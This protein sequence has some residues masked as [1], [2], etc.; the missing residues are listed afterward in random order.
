MSPSIRLFLIGAVL[1]IHLPLAWSQMNIKVG[2]ITGRTEAQSYN[3]IV[4]HF[5]RNIE[6]VYV[7]DD[8][9]DPLR[10]MHGLE[11]GVRYKIRNVGFEL[12]WSGLQKRSDVFASQNNVNRLQSRLFTGLTE[13]SL[14][15]ENYYG[16]FGYGASLGYRYLTIKTDV[17]GSRRKRSEI[18]GEDGWAGKFYLIFSLPG[19]NVA[20]AFKPYIQ[21]PLTEYSMDGFENG[22]NSKYEFPQR[23]FVSPERFFMYGISVVLYNGRQ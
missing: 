19:D 20:L 10:W 16:F 21:F 12:S 6:S 9:L 4:D 15:A 8:A 11:L 13:Y 23:D 5:N 7:L 2:Y 18:L 14:G 3:D 17:P 22:I 1:C